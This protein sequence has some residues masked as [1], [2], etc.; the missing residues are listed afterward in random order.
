MNLRG[1]AVF[2]NGR[3]VFVI[4]QRAQ[5]ERPTETAVGIWSNQAFLQVPDGPSNGV[6]NLW[7][8]LMGKDVADPN[9]VVAGSTRGSGRL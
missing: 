9:S 3:Q 1:V 7:L 4:G 5:N 2:P 6:Q 8:D